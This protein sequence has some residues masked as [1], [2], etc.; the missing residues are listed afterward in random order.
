MRKKPSGNLEFRYN[1]LAYFTIKHHPSLQSMLPNETWASPH[2]LMLRRWSESPKS[3]IRVRPSRK[4]T[5]FHI[6]KFSFHAQQHLTWRSLQ[7]TRKHTRGAQAL[8]IL[9]AVSR[10][11]HQ[12]SAHRPAGLPTGNRSVCQGPA[13]GIPRAR[14][15]QQ[16]ESSPLL[17]LMP[18]P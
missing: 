7:N 5:N 12:Q 3:W 16:S 8:R 4:P 15:G 6:Q 17:F 9:L 10:H 14:L 1:C 13:L 2:F 11:T 18:G